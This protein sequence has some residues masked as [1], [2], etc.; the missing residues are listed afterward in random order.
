MNRFYLCCGFAALLFSFNQAI[1]GGIKGKVIADDGSPLAYATIYVKQIGSGTTTNDEAYY[2]LQLAPGNYELVFQFL[3]YQTQVHQVTVDQEFVILDIVLKSQA[4]MLRSVEIKAGKEDA[5]YSIMRKT[6]SKSKFHLNQLDSF[7]M[8]VYIKGA[9]KMNKIPF[10]ARKQMLEDGVDTSRVFVS[11]SISDIYYRR[12]DNFTEKVIAIYTKGDDNSTSPNSYITNSFYQP[13]IAGIVSPLSPA[14]FSY[15]KFE[16]HG[17]VRDREYEVSKIKVIPRARGENVFEGF[18]Y[19]VEDWWSLHS[20]ELKTTKLG[21]D[22]FINQIYAPIEDKAWMPVSHKFKIDGSFFGFGFIYDYVASVSDYKIFLN[23]DL[24][25]KIEVI[26]EKTEKE[27]AKEVKVKQTESKSL[28]IQERL[29][30][31]EEVTRKDLRKMINEY[32]KQA[33]KESK[34]PEVIST[35]KF[36]IDSLARRKDSTYWDLIRPIP[37]S[38]LEERGYAQMDSI[39][40]VEKNKQEGDSIKTKSKKGFQIYDIL[41]GDNYKLGKRTWLYIESPLSSFMYNTIEGYNFDYKIRLSTAFIDK[42]KKTHTI[43]ISPVA[44]YA[45]SR[46]IVSGYANLN[47]RYN[48]QSWNVR[49]GR[50]IKQFNDAEPIHPLV[51]SVMSSLFYQNYMKLYERDFVDFDYNRRV[52]DNKWNLKVQMSHATRRELFNTS[53]NPWWSGG[54]REGFT[55]NA[56]IN[57]S[58]S[59]T[60]FPTHQA[61]I[62]QVSLSGRP[63]QKYRMRNGN[64]VSVSGSSPLLSFNYR[65]GIKG[66]LESD[67]DYDFVEAGF[68]HTF[69]FGI[70]YVDFAFKAGAFLNN[71]NLYFMDY[72]HHLGNLTPFVTTDPVGSYRMLD[73]Y[74]YSTDR[75]FLSTSVHYQFRRFLVTQAPKL[76]FMG[77]KENLFVNYLAAPE[78]KHYTELGYSLDGILRFFRF[79]L[80]G[81][82]R[83]AKYQGFAV[84]IG[85]A[86][87]LDNLF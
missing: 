16:Y 19:I 25:V 87:N 55:P 83:E 39:A 28:D 75:Q 66:L 18:I 5:A 20:T 51:N 4:T 84:R 85:I 50:Y 71:N 76:R 23:P 81:A 44:R 42:Q 53:L 58:L 2:E 47:Y 49:A 57:T 36:S 59:D 17:T 54:T 8:R 13:E 69:K 12:P 80:V 35:R 78:A 48:R 11:E 31:G 86:T 34:E 52:L 74:L 26:D 67:V 45:F 65:K 40:E 32:E 63:W 62:G 38:S 3:G 29:S 30:S 60:S 73:Y 7:S 21:I 6:I 61:L 9:G 68:K 46:K 64:K 77:M 56:P 27:I 33:L 43:Q 15:Y 24:D 14:A 41:I 22:I 82:F 70:R 1:A 72:A 10:F 79:E 37:L